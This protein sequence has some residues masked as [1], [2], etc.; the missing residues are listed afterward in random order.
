MAWY[1]SQKADRILVLLLQE[2][3]FGDNTYRSGPLLPLTCSNYPLQW[4]GLTK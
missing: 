3:M 4:D 2:A 1:Q